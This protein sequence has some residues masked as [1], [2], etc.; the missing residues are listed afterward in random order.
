MYTRF[1]THWWCDSRHHFWDAAS[2]EEPTLFSFLCYL[3]RL[4]S[5]CQSVDKTR[6]LLCASA[7]SLSPFL[8][9]PPNRLPY[10][11]PGRWNGL[12]RDRRM[13]SCRWHCLFDTPHL[14]SF[15]PD[16]ERWVNFHWGHQT[17]LAYFCLAPSKQYVANFIR[18][19]AVRD[20]H[21]IYT[22]SL[23]GT[24]V[25]RWLWDY[26]FLLV[27]IYREVSPGT[28]PLGAEIL[29]NV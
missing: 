29:L 20:L 2:V 11:H 9:L 26:V 14:Y 5:C 10:E 28:I 16:E 1:L 27:T 22:M 13:T 8:F 17:P 21:N 4:S 19:C 18:V 12:W 15:I 25:G 23:W 24:L 7:S 6:C 3:W